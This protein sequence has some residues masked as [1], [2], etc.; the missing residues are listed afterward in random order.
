MSISN[1]REGIMEGTDHL[2]G[3]LIKMTIPSTGVHEICFDGR[4]F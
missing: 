1:P 3:G 4:Y 2:D